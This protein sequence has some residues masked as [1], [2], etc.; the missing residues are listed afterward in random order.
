MF[1]ARVLSWCKDGWSGLVGGFFHS[2]GGGGGSGDS[3]KG[4]CVRERGLRQAHDKG[5]AGAG[6]RRSW[7]RGAKGRR[8]RR[9]HECF[10]EDVVVELRSAVRK[11]ECRQPAS[12][13]AE[14]ARPAATA[15]AGGGRA[16]E[17]RRTIPTA[18]AR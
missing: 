9:R 3:E 18:A 4:G 6:D 5:A 10:P 14:A 1:G 8:R 11:A 15:A 16:G 2:R 7:R 17:S 12:L 13:R